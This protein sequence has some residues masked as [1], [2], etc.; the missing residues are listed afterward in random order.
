MNK[1]KYFFPHFLAIFSFVII[2]LTY[3]Y[4]VL[5]GKILVQSDITQYNAMDK[6]QSDFR[7]KNHTEPYWNNSAFGGM[8]TYQLGAHYP[9]DMIKKIDSWLRFI[10]RPADY[11]FLYFL[12]FYILLM[13]LKVD[14]LKAF[15]GALAFGFSTYLIIILGVGHNSKAHAIAYMP[16]VLAGFL[17][18][19]DRKYIVGG[20]LTVFA[21]A[22]EIN[23]NHFQMTYY[24]LILLLFIILYYSLLAF[25]KKNF[26]PLV[27]SF[28]TFTIA[29]IFAVAANATSIMATSEYSKTSTRGK[30]ELTYNPDGTKNSDKNGMSREYITGYSYGILESFNIISPRIFGG[31]NNENLGTNSALYEFAIAQ[32]VP[33]EQA[34][35]I[36]KGLPT[37]W[38]DQPGVSAPAYIGAVVFFLAILALFCDNRKIKYAF[39]AGALFSLM[40]SWGK[41]FSVLTDFFID[42]IPMYD[43]FRAVSSIQVILEICFPILAIM[44]F[45]SFFKLK[46]DEQWKNL[47]KTA[48]TTLGILV[49]LLLSKSFFSF[50]GGNDSMLTESYGPDFITALKL[51][52][53]DMFTNDLLRSILFVLAVAFVLWLFIKDKFSKKIA[54]ILVGIFMVSD[55]FFIDKTYVNAEFVTGQPAFV[56]KSDFNNQIEKTPVDAAI[57]EDKSIYRVF[58]VSGNAL[59]NSRTSYFHK[60]I[61]GYSGAKPRRMQQ[62]F[63]YQIAKSNIQVL[64]MLNVKY[65]IQND[66][67]GNQIPVGN[68]FANGNAWFVNTIKKVVNPNEE[69]KALDKINS[70]T[71]AVVNT[72]E[73]PKFAN[74]NAIVN[75]IDSK[76][77][78]VNYASNALKYK[79]NNTNNGI[80]VFSEMYYANGWNCYIDGKL[81]QHFRANY[82]LRAAQIPAGNHTIEFKFEPEVIKTGGK[83]MLCGNIGILLLVIFGLFYENKKRPLF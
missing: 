53:K 20:L 6:E 76:I 3:F 33:E 17:L 72:T 75:G 63:D 46:A 40:L 82:V 1:L 69:M 61:G 83:I 66:K 36:V 52:R 62:I 51:D 29:G 28:V 24:L 7:E 56:S 31:S 59:E 32:N 48:A 70:K 8:P 2:S 5:S 39:F 68:A 38:G 44:G 26:K 55:L 9:Y 18:V 14:P 37:Y 73:F 35:E 15:F 45:Q 12:S 74:Q 13:V 16:L 50:A 11:L 49:L 64:N 22:L 47:W 58:E 43:K 78:L 54:V 21:L 4:P 34:K 19:L 79:S 27:Y 42:Y 30:N 81:T 10:P 25:K 80:A 67:K 23:A 41:N 60:S 65:F 77:Q 57:L 71:M